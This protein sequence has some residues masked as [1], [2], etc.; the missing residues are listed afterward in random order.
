MTMPTIRWTRR[1]LRRLDEIGATIAAADRAA[2]ARVVGRIV[3][4]IDSLPDNPESGRSGRVA[5]TRELVITD[6][7]YVVAY[8][9]RGNE[10]EILTI[11]HS[12]QLWPRAF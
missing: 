6:T 3:E 12:A 7:R 10:I 4:R 1:A 9:L 2:A 5:G 8:R 11:L